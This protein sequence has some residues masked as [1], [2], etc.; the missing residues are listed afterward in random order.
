MIFLYSIFNFQLITFHFN[1]CTTRA[2]YIIRILTLMA[3][4]LVILAVAVAV[5]AVAVAVAVNMVVVAAIVVVAAT[6]KCT[7]TFDA[8]AVET[9]RRN[10]RKCCAVN[11]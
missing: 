4:I 5:A 2:G 7:R 11:V 1:A 3:L 8:T 9:Q 10:H 6:V